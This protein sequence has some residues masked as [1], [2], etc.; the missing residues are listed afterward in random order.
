MRKKESWAES[1]C[2]CGGSTISDVRELGP[3]N[4]FQNFRQTIF[5]KLNHSLATRHQSKPVFQSESQP[6]YALRPPQ[7]PR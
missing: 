6:W 3:F 5:Y 2:F 1:I 7:S 4:L